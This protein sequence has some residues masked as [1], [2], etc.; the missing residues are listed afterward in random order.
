MILFGAE[1][2]SLTHE[3]GSKGANSLSES[4]TLSCALSWFPQG[5][6][7][8]VFPTPWPVNLHMC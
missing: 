7:K 5:D 4:V 1:R 8:S 3:Y 6:E 2:G